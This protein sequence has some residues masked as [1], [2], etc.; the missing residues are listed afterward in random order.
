MA[1]TA[2]VE[3]RTIECFAKNICTVPDE[4]SIAD[5]SYELKPGEQ[6]FRIMT[7]K[8]GDKRIVWNRF[9]M[10]EINAAKKMFDQLISSGMVPYLVGKDGQK[11]SEVM[12]EFDPSAEEVMMS[13]IVFVPQRAIVGG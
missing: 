5:D 2:V 3:D 10:P 4:L 9:K 8:D 1:D 11:T 6:L 13:E 12:K 7:T